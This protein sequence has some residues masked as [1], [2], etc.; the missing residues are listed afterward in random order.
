MKSVREEDP[1][2]KMKQE[3]D[4]YEE[5]MIRRA[6]TGDNEAFERLARRHRAALRSLAMRMLR[7][8]DDASD[9]EQETLV[10]AFRAISEF[11]PVRPLRPWLCRIC[12]NCCVD[13]VR[14]RRR[15][16]ESIEGHEFSL[17]DETQETADTVA[18]VNIEQGQ[19]LGAVERLP[20][21]YRR[22]IVM[23]HFNHMDVNEIALALGKPEGT[24]KS[25][26]FR[27]RALLRKELVP[28][29]FGYAA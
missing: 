17:V 4:R 1:T 21:H 7:N 24:I 14:R 28:A 2:P 23:R 10:K 26:L 27:A 6:A 9:A 22:I 20:E 16:G 8:A 18:T 29:S 15:E 5:D 19:V 3:I 12:A 13:M 11:D 25:W